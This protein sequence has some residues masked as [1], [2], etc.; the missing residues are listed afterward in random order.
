MKIKKLINQII[1]FSLV[2]VIATM[3]DVLL[4]VLLRET[5]LVGVLTASA[6]SFT[7][8]TVIN[9]I[10]SMTFVFEGKFKNKLIE[11]IIFSAI[12]LAGLGINQAIMWIG[13]D[14]IS[15]HYLVVKLFSLVFVTAYNFIVRK[16]FLESKN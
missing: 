3:I 6:I 9:Y 13:T 5:K 14:I 16:V 4:L 1:R 12:S 10:L 11:F 8:S 2:G 15:V 7:V